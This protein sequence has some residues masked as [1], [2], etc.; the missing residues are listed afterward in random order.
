MKSEQNHKSELEVINE[1]LIDLKRRLQGGDSLISCLEAA[2]KFRRF[3]EIA[4]S[5]RKV[6]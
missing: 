5:M 4:K 2:R 1:K 6:E 3:A